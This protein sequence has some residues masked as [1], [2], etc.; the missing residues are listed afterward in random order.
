MQVVKR[1]SD[2]ALV[3]HQGALL[4]NGTMT[5]IRANAD[6]ARVYSGGSK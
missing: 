5:E 3:M 6:V 4:A 2:H 1:L